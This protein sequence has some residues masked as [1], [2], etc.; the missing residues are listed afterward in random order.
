MGEYRMTRSFTKFAAACLLTFGLASVSTAQDNAPIRPL[1]KS[2]SAAFVFSLSGLGDFGLSGPVIGSSAI[3]EAFTIDSAGKVTTVGTTKGG[4]IVM[5]GVGFKFFVSDNMALRLG[6]AFRA[7]EEGKEEID[8]TALGGPRG[9]EQRNTTGINFGAEYHFRPLYSTSP[10]IGAAISFLTDNHKSVYTG[11]GAG[12]TTQFNW[13][14]T[15]FG[16]QAIGGFNWFFT[17]GIA[18]G[19]EYGV[20][21][22]STSTVIERTSLGITK[23]DEPTNTDVGIGTNGGG[24]I[25]FVVYF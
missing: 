3:P 7:F 16:V 11:A 10:Y 12:N 1:T 20:G 17:E 8:Q 22:A 5:P 6:L 24:N 18:L 13:K 23:Q 21:F 14:S 19:A 9:K 4:N 2:G 15:S 25:N